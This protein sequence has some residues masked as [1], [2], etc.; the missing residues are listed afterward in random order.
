MLWYYMIVWCQHIMMML[1][2]ESFEIY[3]QIQYQDVNLF[4]KIFLKVL[5]HNI[6][7]WCQHIMMMLA[8]KYTNPCLIDANTCLIDANTCLIDANTQ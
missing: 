7:V 4:K 1:A 2:N 6:I 8:H 5:W 3:T